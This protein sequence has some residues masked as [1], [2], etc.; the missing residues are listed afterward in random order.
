MSDKRRTDRRAPPPSAKTDPLLR[1][2]KDFVVEEIEVS[3]QEVPIAPPAGAHHKPRT[4]LWPKIQS[5]VVPL[6]LVTLLAAA[7]LVT[8]G[9]WPGDETRLLAIAWEMWTRGDWL[10][11]RFNGEVQALPPL[12]FWIV[13]LG[14]RVFGEVD[15]WPRLVPVLFLLGSLLI[16]SRLA[17]LL[18]AGQGAVARQLPLIMIGSFTLALSAA[19]F[20]LPTTVM[21]FALLFLHALLWRWRFRDHRL[22]LL[23]G[24]TLGLGLLAGGGVLLLYV[25]PVALL[26]PLWGRRQPTVPWKYWY[27]DLFKA[28]V[29]ATVIFALWFLPAAGRAG[30]KTLLPLFTA[31]TE[32]LALDLFAGERPWWWLLFLLPWLAFPWSLWPL[33]W[34][35]LWHVRSKPLG[36]GLSFC[37]VWAVTVIA[38][39]SALP[40][41]QPQFLLPLAPAFFLVVAWLLL[42]ERHDDHDH[43][44]LATAIT[45]PMLLLGGVLAV[46]PQ[47][48]R[49]PYLPEFLW[50]LSPFVGVAVIA[51]GVAIGWLPIPSLDT[52]LFNMAAT[53]AVLTALGLLALG[54]QL[55]PHYELARPAE[56]IAKAQQRGQPV[57][58]VGRYHGEYHFAGRLRTPLEVLAPEQVPAWLAANPQ[59]LLVSHL[60]S[61]TPPAAED[62]PLVVVLEQPYGDEALRLW[63]AGG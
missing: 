54:W 34:L 7:S 11:P 40:G 1:N 56:L 30:A 62:A 26:A 59:G 9:L 6:G 57:A 47:L 22:W 3:S 43:S 38:V 63:K 36:N 46:L 25:L 37:L 51:L 24:L 28:G 16:A 49:V 13:Q 53:V 55:Q 58:H 27:A 15:W 35:R 33:P 29:L 17:L 18:W 44:K 41:R 20:A 61:W 12:F 32:I 48:P 21:F 31:P 5:V 19:L 60:A 14:W 2:L 45:F 4:R 10:V 23:M 52:R 50:G 8:R 39:F 42:D